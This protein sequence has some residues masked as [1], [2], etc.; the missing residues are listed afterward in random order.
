MRIVF[1]M[2][3][4]P[5]GH[6][7]PSGDLIIGSGLFTHLRQ[8]GHRI[9][10]ASRLRVRWLYWKPWL[11][12]RLLSEA[13]QIVRQ[14]RLAPPDL[15]LT[16]HSYY[17]A[18]DALGALC[19]FFRPIPYFIFQGVYSTKRRRHWKTRPGF[20]INRWVLGRAAAVFTNKRRDEINLK[21]LLPDDRVHYIAP[22][23]D[24]ALFRHDAEARAK[25]RREWGVSETPV[26]LTA[27][28]LRPG[29]K[30]EGLE[31]TIR[32]CQ[33]IRRSGLAFRLVVCGEGA[34]GPHLR[35]LARRSLGDDACFAGKIPREEMYRF[36]SAAD[37][38]AFPGIQEGLGM[39][40]L[41]AQACGLPV[42][43]FDRWGASE[44]V[45]DGQ[46]GLL[47]SAARPHTFGDALERLIQDDDLRRGL[48]AAAKH[49]VR[50]DHDLDR[51]LGRFER[52]LKTMV[53]C[54]S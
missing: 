11:W 36:Y 53:G 17:K 25:L 21:R 23:V 8:S 35:A 40:Y 42:V 45:K 31:L 54:E 41:E 38:F 13:A 10:L 48:G 5:L 29:V 19:T 3:F 22:G 52:Q 39:V 7:N 2:P 1:Y 20:L 44:V 16:Y 34:S 26:I 12:L 46:T 30:T 47:C 24:T 9:T 51:N 14:L 37:I 6:R 33:A 43:A 27:A 28:M 18:P 50:T 4:K 49:H 32:A 15:W